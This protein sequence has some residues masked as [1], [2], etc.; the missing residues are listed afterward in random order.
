M[1]SEE[2]TDR[3]GS[4]TDR[5]GRIGWGENDPRLRAS[6]RVLLALV[7][8]VVTTLAQL[9]AIAGISSLGVT[10]SRVEMASVGI[11]LGAV[12]FFALLVPWARYIDRRPLV[13]YGF[14]RC[15]R[16]VTD[17]GVGFLAVAVGTGL[18]YAVGVALGW[19]TVELVWAYEGGP[20]GLWVGL[21]VVVWGV[22]GAYQATLYYGLWLK[23]AA[24][25]LASR[26]LSPRR[27]VFVAW[28]V[29]V[30]LFVLRHTPGDLGEV[31]VLLAGG[32]VF[33]AMY[34]HSGELALPIA[35]IGW[36]NFVN[37]VLFV[38]QDIELET[39]VVFEVTQ[40][41]PAS[42]TPLADP[43]LP[44]MVVAYLVVATWL[45]WRR[46][47]LSIDTSLTRWTQR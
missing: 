8:F 20:V 38:P 9:A 42:L 3:P 5:L 39:P 19:T 43:R 28:A 12:F 34:V 37:L 31:G 25:G 27:A 21:M 18:W 6:W 46:D 15:W 32:T 44:Q 41:L 17:L 45:Q 10:L 35:A 16:W 23:T 22:S 36:G 13:D 2:G 30:V 4:A 29:T 33:G 26:G 7:L 1:A 40:S 14:E 47:G 11:P 24:E